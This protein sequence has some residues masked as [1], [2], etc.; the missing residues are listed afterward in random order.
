VLVSG[1]AVSPGA[2]L[3]EPGKPVDYYVERTGGYDEDAN[4]GRVVVL[5]A[6][7]AVLR[8]D[9]V[10]QVEVGDIIIIPSRPV[11]LREKDTW[12]EV[13]KALSAVASAAMTFYLIR[14]VR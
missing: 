14:E 2:V 4:R 7:G 10:K 13:G 6:D 11:I 3:F 12:G 9:L 5:R 1:A 8:R